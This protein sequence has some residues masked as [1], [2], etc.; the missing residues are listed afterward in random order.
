MRRRA[1]APPRPVLIIG[2]SVHCEDCGGH[3]DHR[4]SRGQVNPAREVYHH[5]GVPGRLHFV[6]TS[7][8][9]RPNGPAI[10]PAWQGFFVRWLKPAP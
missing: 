6:L 4:R 9:H 5:L 10:D 2:G 7:D 1:L 3:S 8:G